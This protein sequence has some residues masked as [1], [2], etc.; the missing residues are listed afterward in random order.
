MVRGSLI[1]RPS[2]MGLLVAPSIVQGV[3]TYLITSARC[4]ATGSC[5]NCW[6]S[7]THLPDPLKVGDPPVLVCPLEDDPDR[8][9]LKLG[10]RCLAQQLEGPAQ[11]RGRLRRIEPNGAA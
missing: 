6:H 2:L 10:R 1:A 8:L 7:D 5:G 11:Q 3:R 4:A 9:K